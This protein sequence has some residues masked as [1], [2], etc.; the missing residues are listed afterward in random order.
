MA[1]N[2]VGAQGPQGR[3][4][5]R[6]LAAKWR[7]HVYRHGFPA[8]IHY[9]V[10]GLGDQLLCTAV[11]YELRK[12]GLHGGLWWISDD[13][14]HFRACP[15]L[16]PLLPRDDGLMGHAQ[17]RGVN[18]V[19]LAYEK[20]HIGDQVTKPP[21]EHYIAALCRQAGITGEIDLR[22]RWPESGRAFAPNRHPRVATHSSVL[23]ARF[24]IRNKQWP[25][26]RMQEVVATLLA[27]ADFV[28]LGDVRDPPLIGARDRRGCSLAQ[29]AE[30]LRAADLFI[31]MEGFLMH[32]ARAVDCPAVIVHGGRHPI[33]LSGYSCNVNLEIR[34]ACSPCWRN[35]QCDYGR[36]CL[37]AI[38]VEQVA[39]AARRLLASPPARPLARE[40][41]IIGP[42]AEP[43]TVTEVS[44]LEVCR[45]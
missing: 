7:R 34:P 5:R 14:R 33:A 28:Q 43:P 17:E 9:F 25:V 26:E 12:R 10:G 8:K 27:Q 19:R 18:I 1:E 35:E 29:A 37:E 36:Q 4:D 44:G 38:T 22:P 6:R 45:N 16:R 40:F 24:P 3:A 31:G 11:A 32:L 30:V 13:A 39:G 23:H 41:R 20:E 15:E 2:R 21:V 42:H